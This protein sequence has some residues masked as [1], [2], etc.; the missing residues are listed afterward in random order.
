MGLCTCLFVRVKCR[1]WNELY[2]CHYKSHGRIAFSFICLCSC[3][4]LVVNR[5]LSCACVGR[6]DGGCV[7]LP[8]ECNKLPCRYAIGC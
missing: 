2:V 6:K 3:S 8:K 4:V 1:K 7:D 5:F